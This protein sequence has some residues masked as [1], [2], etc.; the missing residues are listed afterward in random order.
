MKGSIST[1]TLSGYQQGLGAF[2]NVRI[3]Y[4]HCPPIFMIFLLFVGAMA[5]G[6]FISDTFNNIAAGWI[7]GVVI[8]AM[9]GFVIDRWFTG[10][11]ALE[12]RIRHRER[13]RHQATG[14]APSTPS[15]ETTRQQPAQHA[16]ATRESTSTSA[17]LR[18]PQSTTTAR[19][20]WSPDS[21]HPNI[22]GECRT[23]QA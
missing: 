7:A 15:P 5:G 11:R 12:R 4:E 20:G 13:A 1:H 19:A 22:L 2:G 9:L 23:P 3:E 14:R 8:L 16:S 6:I 10:V 21:T 18:H 17:F